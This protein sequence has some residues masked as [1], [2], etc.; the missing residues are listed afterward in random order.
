MTGLKNNTT[1]F[2][3]VNSDGVNSSY[4]HGLDGTPDIIFFKNYTSQNFFVWS[5]LIPDQVL[6]LDGSGPAEANTQLF[7]PVP[8]ATTV[9]LGTSLTSAGF[10]AWQYRAIPGYSAMGNY[11]GNGNA[12]G[13]FIYTGFTPAFVLRKATTGTLNWLIQDSTRNPNNPAN[14]QLEPNLD[15]YETTGND[16]D[17]LSNGFKLRS[18]NADG[19]TATTYIY[20]AFAE[21]PFGGSNV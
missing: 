18:T 2:S 12:D 14:T 15:L 10:I 20:A 8:D 16:I 5:A 1:Q 17:L 4:E 13:P 7:T 11:T 3:I 21:N 19:G 6:Y 9:S